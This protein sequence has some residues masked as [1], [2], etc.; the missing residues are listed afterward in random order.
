MIYNLNGSTQE[1]SYTSPFFLQT[2]YEAKRFAQNNLDKINIIMDIETHACKFT[3]TLHKQ[4]PYYPP[5]FLL[6]IKSEIYR[7]ILSSKIKIEEFLKQAEIQ[8]KNFTTTTKLPNFKNITEYFK[9]INQIPDDPN[10]EQII[11]TFKQA[12]QE[13]EPENRSSVSPKVTFQEPIPSARRILQNQIVDQLNFLIPHAF[14]Q[15][16]LL[17]SP[18]FLKIYTILQAASIDKTLGDPAPNESRFITSH[19]ALCQIIQKPKSMLKLSYEQ[20]ELTNENLGNY[21]LYLHTNLT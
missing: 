15:K 14:K 21:I 17:I 12:L 1:F 6:K 9:H 19:K 8:G 10:F 13:E 2:Q 18:E 20:L 7:T 4:H 5:I 11:N 16:S 3:Q